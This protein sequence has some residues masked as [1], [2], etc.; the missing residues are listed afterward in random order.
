[1]LFCPVVGG[2]ELCVVCPVGGGGEHCVVCPVGGGGEH[3]VVCPV[4]GGG[5]H[6]VC[7]VGGGVEH[8]VCPV[9]GGGEHCVVCLVG[10]GG[11]HCVVCPVDGGGEHCVVCPVGGG[12]E[13]C[14]E[15]HSSGEG[16][17]LQELYAAS[18]GA[19]SLPRLLQTP[20]LGGHP[21]LVCCSGILPGVRSGTR[22][23]P[24]TADPDHAPDKPMI[25][26][27]ETHRHTCSN[28]TVHTVAET[29]IQLHTSSGKNCAQ[30]RLK[31]I[32]TQI[33]MYIKKDK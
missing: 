8:C 19:F 11:E 1:M 27:P 22:P 32:H 25:T 2:G 7:P 21:R 17:R 31:C 5:E 4:G 14:G 16:L 29:Q 3:C 28:Y 30:R 12:G 10:G 9:G 33:K 26:C 20:A 6:C 15:P 13:H 18:R 24:G 23:A